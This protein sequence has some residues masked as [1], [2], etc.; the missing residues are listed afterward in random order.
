[1]LQNNINIKD[2]GAIN[3]EF[4]DKMTSIQVAGEQW[5]VNRY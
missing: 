3:D 4:T 1:M 2:F 5:S